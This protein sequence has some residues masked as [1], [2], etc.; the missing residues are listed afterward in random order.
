MQQEM[1]AN[2]KEIKEDIRTNHEE[3]NASREWSIAKLG[4]WLAEM[5]A[6]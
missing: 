1:D 6:W 4:A 2:L 5:R 3:T